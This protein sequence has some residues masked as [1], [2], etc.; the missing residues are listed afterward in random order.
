MKVHSFVQFCT[1]CKSTA[2]IVHFIINCECLALKSQTIFFT[3]WNQSFYSVFENCGY[4]LHKT[5][6]CNTC[7]SV[8]NLA[9]KYMSGFCWNEIAKHTS[10][11]KCIFYGRYLAYLWL[12][13][14]DFRELTKSSLKIYKDNESRFWFKE[15]KE[16]TLH[17]WLLSFP[18]SFLKSNN[19]NKKAIKKVPDKFY[20]FLN[21]IVHLRIY[22]VINY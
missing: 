3:L 12:C 11:Y 9:E 22:I 6:L 10:F 13:S 19:N 7:L 17:A 14:V 16:Q 8:W 20:A 2:L 5:F 21:F 4:I 18:S 1:K 15:L